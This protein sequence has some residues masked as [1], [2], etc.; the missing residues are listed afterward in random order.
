MATT[1]GKS[2][3]QGFGVS[4][5]LI[6]V[7]R[8]RSRQGNPF[9]FGLTGS[10]R[11]RPKL[12]VPPL[13]PEA[14]PPAC[15]ERSVWKSLD[16]FERMAGLIGLQ[17][18]L[19]FCFSLQQNS[20]TASKGPLFCAKSLEGI[21]CAAGLARRPAISMCCCARNFVKRK[22]KCYSEPIRKEFGLRVVKA[23]KSLNPC[24]KRYRRQQ[25]KKHRS[26]SRI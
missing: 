25:K 2:G 26:H 18:G 5:R 7:A 21:E 6:L 9:H 24:L 4:I 12:T 14:K 17:G 20:Q 13:S 8:S 11:R 23:R 1:H 3:A 10:M 19:H 15:A 16:C 22:A